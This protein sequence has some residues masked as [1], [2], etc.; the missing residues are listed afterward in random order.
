MPPSGSFAPLER[1]PRLSDTVAEHL[2][3][4]I[5]SRGLQPG[6]RLPTER[7]LAAQFA[8]SRTVIR[9]AVRALAGKGIIEARPGRGLT[10]SLVAADSVT[11]SVSLYLHG[12]PTIDY[13]KVHEVRT[14][15]EVQ[16]ASLAAQRATTDDVVLL[17]DACDRLDRVAD[18][19]VAASREDME[20]HRLLATAT[21][22]ELFGVLLAAVGGPLR[23]IRREA[24]AIAGRAAVAGTAHRAILRRVRE[25]DPAGARLEMRSHLDDIEH[26]WEGLVKP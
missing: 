6:D 15:L 12:S 20:F 18:D 3:A 10:V 26:L 14:V 9:E 22:N 13:R 23:D 11:E 4:S 8:V 17:S 1:R 5:V 25:G 19:V 16:V 21:H 24:F 7:E 2:L